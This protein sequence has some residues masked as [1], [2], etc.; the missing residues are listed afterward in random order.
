MTYGHFPVVGFFPM[1]AKGGGL[2][3]GLKQL[4]CLER[5]SKAGGGKKFRK[6]SQSTAT[7]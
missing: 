6:N 7:P 5:R 3:G 1:A 2:G 4:G